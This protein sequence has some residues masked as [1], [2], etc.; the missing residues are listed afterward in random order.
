[1]ALLNSIVNVLI[2]ILAFTVNHSSP[3]TG[4]I[5]VRLGNYRVNRNFITLSGFSSGG[6]FAQQLYLSYSSLI[7]GIA[8]FSHTYYRCGPVTSRQEEYDNACTKLGNRRVSELY[9]PNNALNDIQNYYAQRLIE[10]PANLVN[11]P[12]YVYAGTRNW[13]F[14]ADMSLRILQVFEPHIRNPKVIRTVVQDANLTLPTARADFPPCSGPQNSLQLGNCGLSGPLDALQF[15]LGEPAIRQPAT[16]VRLEPL[17][18]FDQSEF[19]YGASS[20]RYD[21]DSVGY[22]YVPRICGSNQV[23]CLIHFYFHGCSV[24]RQFT[25]EDHIRNSGYLEVAET[26]G[27]IMV[28]PQAIASAEN[29]IGCW[30]SY[31]FTGSLYATQRGSQV[32]AVRNMISR[33]LREDS[34]PTQAPQL[35]QSESRRSPAPR[36]FVEDFLNTNSDVFRI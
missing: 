7:H 35:L 6:S 5:P 11:K 28:F 3:Q 16:A 15:L 27:I 10:N 24:G 1:M 2:L 30:D 17:L 25:G 33:I 23:D 21:M 26:N 14:T 34:S 22:L 8:V 18:T 12:L 36:S 13:L 20:T 32:T 9:D 31:G 19:F 29:D 4:G